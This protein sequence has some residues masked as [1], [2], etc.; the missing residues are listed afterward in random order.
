MAE[1][2]QRW[3]LGRAFYRPARTPFD[4]RAYDVAPLPEAEARSFVVRHHYSATYPVA[5]FRFGLYEGDT[6]AGV[7]VFSVPAGPR[8][9]ARVF[10][11]APAVELGRF[12]LL[13]RVG[14]NA[15]TWMLGQCFAA[16]RR[17]GLAGV[18]SFAD[19]VARTTADGRRVFPGHVGTIYQAHN[20]RYLGRATPRSLRVL[21]DGRVFSDRAASKVRAGDRGWR[22]A[23][24]QLEDAGA[25]PLEDRDRRA[26]LRQAVAQV[27]RTMRH[28][29]NHR[30][31][32]P[33]DRA[34]SLPPGGR[35]PKQT[36]E[37]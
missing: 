26:W 20:G 28:P 23:A 19:P 22:Y 9:L 37:A 3:R 15:E 2:C 30:Y 33:L 35:Y 21:P 32:W 6:L 27:T 16:L 36:E 25:V 14:A 4:P 5:R 18:L 8:V 17:E 1:V 12:V 24:A 31:A 29:G 7:A 10:G 11:T 13:D 34:V